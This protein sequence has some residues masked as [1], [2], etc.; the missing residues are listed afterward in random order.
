MT[1]FDAPDRETCVP[2]RARTN[3]P[4]QAL[5]LLNDPTYVEAARALAVQTIR[6]GGT[7]VPE[8][9]TWAFHRAVARD[10]TPKEIAVLSALYWKHRGE[11]SLDRAA[12]EKLLGVGEHPAPKEI[13][14]RELAAWT[15]VARVV[16]NIYET[17]TRE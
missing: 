11:Y 5:I 2:R 14:A 15:S 1:T 13:D 6:V 4:L 16:L 3:T 17:V 8:R 7:R 10:P 12:A 9:L